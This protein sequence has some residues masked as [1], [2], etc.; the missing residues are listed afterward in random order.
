L[1]E[2]R[3]KFEISKEIGKG[4]VVAVTAIMKRSKSILQGGKKRV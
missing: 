1:G 4:E 3:K 2:G